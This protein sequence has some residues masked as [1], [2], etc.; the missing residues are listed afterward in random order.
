M[1]LPC[2]LCMPL[3]PMKAETVEPE[4]TSLCVCMCIPLSLPGN[5]TANSFCGIEFTRDNRRTVRRVVF[6]AIRVVSKE[7]LLVLPR[8]PC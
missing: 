1:R 3:W 4:V 2:R 7:S 8:I 5:G 6:C